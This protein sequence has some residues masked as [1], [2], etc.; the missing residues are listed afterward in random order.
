MVIATPSAPS[1]YVNSVVAASVFTIVDVAML[2]PGKRATKQRSFS[3]IIMYVSVPTVNTVNHLAYG[4]LKVFKC[5][6]LKV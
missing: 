5:Y 2:L 1:S 6:G 4:R 3:T